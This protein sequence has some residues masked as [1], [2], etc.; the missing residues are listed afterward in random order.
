MA[1]LLGELEALLSLT[2]GA[3][4][5]RTAFSAGTFAAVGLLVTTA[6]VAF[7]TALAVFL[8]H[9]LG[10]VAALGIVAAAAVVL[11]AIL[12]V[13]ARSANRAARQKAAAEA[14][15]RS[16]AIAAAIRLVPERMASRPLVILA[17]TG[18]GFGLGQL[19]C[20]RPDDE[21]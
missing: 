21:A 8:G 5:K 10:M 9:R 1:N 7:V 20:R 11:A 16:L 4:A 12:A 17:A 15:V 19:L 14:R 6:Y 2:V 18:I 3:A 13:I